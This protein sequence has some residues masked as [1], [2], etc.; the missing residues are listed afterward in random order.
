[1]AIGESTHAFEL[2][3]DRTPAFREVAI[4][5]HMALV[6]EMMVLPDVDCLGI[7]ATV[8]LVVADRLH[9]V[10]CTALHHD[11]SVRAREGCRFRWHEPVLLL[12]HAVATAELRSEHRAAGAALGCRARLALLGALEA[13]PMA[14]AFFLHQ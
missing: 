1:M 6:R 7:V 5:L 3:L 10:L 2:L 12:W 11:V 14:L 4:V 8:V 13:V 9:A